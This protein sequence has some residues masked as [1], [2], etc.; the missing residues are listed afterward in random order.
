MRLNSDTLK[1]RYM[2][3]NIGGKRQAYKL[4][5]GFHDVNSILYTAYP[6]LRFYRKFSVVET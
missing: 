5:S 4:P 3:N 2:I 6:M 1:E